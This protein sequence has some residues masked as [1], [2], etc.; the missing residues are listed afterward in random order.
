MNKNLLRVTYLLA[1]S[2][3][4][5]AQTLPAQ[6]VSVGYDE[7]ADTSN[8]GNPGTTDNTV[9]YTITTSSDASNIY[10]AFDPNTSKGGTFTPGTNDFTNLYFS[11]TVA[12]G[13]GGSNI[14]IEVQNDRAF[15]PGVAGYYDL[16]G[17][18]VT[19]TED[20]SGDISVTIPLAV[21]ENDPE[22]I[23]GF[24]DLGGSNNILR[25]NLSQSY[26]YSVAGGKANYGSTELG[27]V[28]VTPEPSSF[29]LFAVG[30]MA[31]VF[32]AARRS[33]DL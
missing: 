2:M 22:G 24:T 6:T 3:A 17:D 13:T 4:P 25:L 9:A 15:V 16:A 29:G 32:L 31:V 23:P 14:G 27:E 18:G 7:T 33:I 1:V 20:A 28:I 12:E 10:L 5:L 8:F 21:F 30:L 26:G 19:S 11:T